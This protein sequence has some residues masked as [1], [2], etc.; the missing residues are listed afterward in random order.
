M[1]DE[2]NAIPAY[3]T[4]H[5]GTALVIGAAPDA[6]DEYLAATQRLL[7]RPYTIAV[8]DMADRVPCDAI[9][10]CHA[11]SVAG[12]L[13]KMTASKYLNPTVHYYPSDQRHVPNSAPNVNHVWSGP[14]AGSGTSSLCAALIAKAI[15]FSKVILCGVPLTKTGYVEGYPEDGYSEFSVKKGKTMNGTL[16]QRHE[17]WTKF[18][19]EGLLRGVTSVSG[20]TK[21]LLGGPDFEG[22]T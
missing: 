7:S 12:I 10:T 22:I 5:G 6:V 19:H 2:F 17:T 14:P 20:F 8:N 9:A 11:E 21:D 16:V 1:S 18:Y 13:A 3:P 15:G 4:K